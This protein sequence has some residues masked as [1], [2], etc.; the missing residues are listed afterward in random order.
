MRGCTLE[1]LLVMNEWTLIYIHVM[2][3]FFHVLVFFRT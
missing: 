2:Q 1:M 3:F